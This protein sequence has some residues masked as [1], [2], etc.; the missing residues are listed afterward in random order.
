M[1]FDD[2]RPSFHLL[3]V[4]ET[5]YP[6]ALPDEDPADWPHISGVH[7]VFRHLDEERVGGELS[8]GPTG[9]FDDERHFVPGPQTRLAA[10]DILSVQAEP[11]AV[12]AVT[13]AGD[14][15][16]AASKELKPPLRASDDL[17]IVEAVVMPG[18]QLVGRTAQRLQLRRRFEVSLLAVSRAGRPVHSRLMEHV[19]Q[20]GDIIALQGW[21]NTIYDTL[22]DLGC[23]PLADLG[24][25]EL[26]VGV[27]SPG[28][29]E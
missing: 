27:H 11:A 8:T 23:L 15:E 3:N 17:E 21:G 19:L 10:G 20:P 1:R 29:R 26:P 5:H 25:P 14:L 12:K 24:M 28:S 2:G 6:Y 4:G 9:F 22:S 18:S 13:N 16:L 7:G